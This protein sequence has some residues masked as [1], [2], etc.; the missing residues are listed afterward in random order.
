M[1]KNKLYIAIILIVAMTLTLT[2]CG[3]KNT[4]KAFLKSMA[5]GLQNRWD[6][7]DDS[8]QQDTKENF[9]KLIDTELKSISKYE[10]ADFKDKKLGEY[11]K[12]YIKNL[13]ETKKLLDSE[14]YSK[15]QKDYAGN[16]YKERLKLIK[17][18]ESDYKIPVDNDHEDFIEDLVDQADRMEYANQL[19]QEFN[20]KR[21]GDSDVYETTVKNITNKDMD[22]FWVE[23]NL[24]DNGQV[25]GV[26]TLYAKDWKK[27]EEKTFQFESDLGFDTVQVQDASY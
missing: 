13:K 15:F 4:D 1:K 18:I 26:K 9:K 5:E 3:Q 22:T 19:Y 11:A 2:A 27:G 12:A 23:L 25:I 20:F 17:E 14:P 10:D 16:L 8:G 21:V 7:M 6:T 24:L